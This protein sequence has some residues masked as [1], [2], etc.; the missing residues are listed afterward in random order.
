VKQRVMAELGAAEPL[1]FQAGVVID[2]IN[3]PP[4]AV[5]P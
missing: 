1:E 4:K 5:S 3:A 2:R